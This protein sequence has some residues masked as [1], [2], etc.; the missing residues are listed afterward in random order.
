[1]S[2]IKVTAEPR[3]QKRPPGRVEGTITINQISNKFVS[4]CFDSSVTIAPP[5]T[6]QK[7]KRPFAGILDTLTPKRANIRF[8]D[9]LPLKARKRAGNGQ[10]STRPG[11]RL[12]TTPTRAGA[13]RARARVQVQET[14]RRD[15]TGNGC[16][17]RP[18]HDTK[19]TP[20]GV[21]P[22]DTTGGKCPQNRVKIFI[23]CNNIN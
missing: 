1:M 17:I 3:T 18:S 14:T 2:N 5:G 11:R 10:I 9:V 7:E 16:K 13:L 19:T 22:H 15:R 4:K 8:A 12:Q 21:N 20:G 23:Y 6:A